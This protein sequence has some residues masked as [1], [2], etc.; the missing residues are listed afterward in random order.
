MY[1]FLLF[2]FVSAFVWFFVWRPGP[3]PWIE[4]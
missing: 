2:L 4:K 3:S 1:D